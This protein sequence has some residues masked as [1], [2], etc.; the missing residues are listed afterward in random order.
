MPTQDQKART[1]SNLAGRRYFAGRPARIAVATCK[2]PTASPP[3][4]PGS[5]SKE[6]ADPQASCAAGARREGRGR[7]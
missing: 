7:G 6:T 4:L 3:S 5:S 2:A 1:I